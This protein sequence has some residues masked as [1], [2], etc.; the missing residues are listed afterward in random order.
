M[1][2]LP[3]LVAIYKVAVIILRLFFSFAYNP[4]CFFLKLQV[5]ITAADRLTGHFTSL[6][7]W[8]GE[9][10]LLLY[11]HPA[12]SIICY[13]LASFSLENFLNVHVS[14]QLLPL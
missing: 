14:R 7:G 12:L 3:N 2:A 5:C 13:L 1:C 9:S 8:A 4:Q 10:K 6:C 11:D